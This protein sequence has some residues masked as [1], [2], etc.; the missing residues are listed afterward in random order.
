M[1]LAKARRCDCANRRRDRGYG[2]QV[3]RAHECARPWITDRGERL[4]GTQLQ[5]AVSENQPAALAAAV[6]ALLARFPV[7]DAA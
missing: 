3:R 1:Y 6:R 7:R 2:I 4:D 5:F